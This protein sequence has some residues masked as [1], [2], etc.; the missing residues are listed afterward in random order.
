MSAKYND[1]CKIL[2]E[3]YEPAQFMSSNSGISKYRKLS[4]MFC[5]EYKD[6][7]SQFDDSIKSSIIKNSKARFK[8]LLQYNDVKTVNDIIKNILGDLE[9]VAIKENLYQTKSINIAKHIILYFVIHYIFRYNIYADDSSDRLG[10]QDIIEACFYSKTKHLQ[11]TDPNT[12]KTYFNQVI[13]YCEM[14]ENT[15]A[16]G[17]FGVFISEIIDGE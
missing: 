2:S 9:L 15:H 13:G 10:F 11:N 17:A 7:F 4:F 12:D 14:C 5:V 8:R 6:I 16:H 1:Y 3:I